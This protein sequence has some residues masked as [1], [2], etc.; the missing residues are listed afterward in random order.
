MHCIAVHLNNF[1]TTSMFPSTVVIGAIFYTFHILTGFAL[2]VAILAILDLYKES[3]DAYSDDSHHTPQNTSNRQLSFGLFTTE[4]ALLCMRVLHRLVDTEKDISWCAHLRN[5]YI[6]FCES[7]RS[8]TFV[9]LVAAYLTSA[10]LHFTLFYITRSEGTSADLIILAHAVVAAFANVAYFVRERREAV[11][12]QEA[13]EQ[14]HTHSSA[15]HHDSSTAASSGSLL[16]L[17]ATSDLLRPSNDPLPMELQLREL[18]ESQ[19]VKNGASSGNE[20]GDMINGGGGTI[21]GNR[22][23]KSAIHSSR[24]ISY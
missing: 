5:A 9:L 20:G 22:A 14:E 18:R 23:V 1:A 4:I 24:K 21:R 12:R 19:A 11:R 15:S 8:R 10:S 3:A 16:S 2:L 6:K 17:S 7:C 13:E